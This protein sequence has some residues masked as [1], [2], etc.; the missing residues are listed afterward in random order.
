MFHQRHTNE[1][2]GRPIT[3]L[4]ENAKRLL[5]L[6]PKECAVVHGLA[7]GRAPKQL[8][9]DAG[10]SVATIRCHIQSAKRKTSAR[11]LPQLVAIRTRR[12]DPIS[13]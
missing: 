2:G 9:A 11:T 1:V 6:S 10:V 4:D 13:R 3:A 7:T 8:A 12:D 5:D